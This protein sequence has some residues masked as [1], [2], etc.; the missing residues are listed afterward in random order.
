LLLTKGRVPAAGEGA[1]DSSSAPVYLVL[2]KVREVVRMLQEDGWHLVRT[3]GSY[4]QFKHPI[5]WLNRRLKSGET[6]VFIL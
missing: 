4:Q 1:V 2:V 5:T 3:R 6:I